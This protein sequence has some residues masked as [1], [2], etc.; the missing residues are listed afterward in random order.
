MEVHVCIIRH[1]EAGVVAV[2]IGQSQDE[3]WADAVPAEH[4]LHAYKQ[5]ELADDYEVDYVTKTLN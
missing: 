2:G 1:A 4:P 5:S 3:A